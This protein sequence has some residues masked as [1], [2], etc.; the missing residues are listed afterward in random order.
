[1]TSDLFRVRISKQQRYSVKFIQLTSTMEPINRPDI[2][3]WLHD[4]DNTPD[5][6]IAAEIEVLNS[7]GQRS[8]M[9][10]LT[11]PLIMEAALHWRGL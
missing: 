10:A 6:N 8:T 1:M 2:V 3:N 7:L 9:K 5:A 11:P 4:D